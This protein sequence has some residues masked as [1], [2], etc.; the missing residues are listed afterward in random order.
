VG[1][2]KRSC[3][4]LFFFEF[5]WPQEKKFPAAKKNKNPPKGGEPL[6]A[7]KAKKIK[8]NIFFDMV[9]F[10]VNMLYRGQSWLL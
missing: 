3:E 9:P 10:G 1:P 8:K 4:F 2:S 7:P 5:L 6:H